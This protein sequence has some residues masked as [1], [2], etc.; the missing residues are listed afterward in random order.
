MSDSGH[1]IDYLKPENWGGE[2]P[3]LSY[4]NLYAK[5]MQRS[6]KF[7]EFARL[8]DRAED[9][10]E[11]APAAQLIWHLNSGGRRRYVIRRRPD[12]VS[13]SSPQ[14]DFLLQ[15]EVTG[16]EVAL[17]VTTVY[18]RVDT[19]GSLPLRR[20]IVRDLNGALSAHPK[21]KEA[22]GDYRIYVGQVSM[23]GLA[24]S[25]AVSV[26]AQRILDI[27]P[28]TSQEAEEDAEEIIDKP[29]RLRIIRG[30]S[31]GAFR[32]YVALEEELLQKGV[33][34]QALEELDGNSDQGQTL[35]EWAEDWAKN[36]EIPKDVRVEVIRALDE[37]RGKFRSFPDATSAM[38]ITL[39]FELLDF[40]NEDLP[41]VNRLQS[42]RQQYHH[43][44]R[45]YIQH[46]GLDSRPWTISRVW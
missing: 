15:D 13:R 27:A 9:V 16:G 31:R 1:V 2:V 26:A 4:L 39:R 24:R 33:A 19:S 10:L 35:T 22:R 8:L 37:A 17:E 14:P 25:R 18:R 40:L 45:L 6:G 28:A 32:C 23:R 29:F 34:R 21:A 46:K 7:E 36:W 30:P 38:L 41:Y 20:L 43:L 44:D 5:H 11:F 12:R 3:G 42:V